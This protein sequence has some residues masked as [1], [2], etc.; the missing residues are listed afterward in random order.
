RSIAPMRRAAALLAL[1]AAPLAAPRRGGAQAAPAGA[2]R[3]GVQLDDGSAPIL[4][5]KNAG[6]FE[7]AG[8]A[9]DIQKF[10]SGT[11]AAAAVAGGSLEIARSNPVALVTAHAKDVPFQVIAP[12]DS[13][14]TDHPDLGMI[15]LTGSKL[16]AARDFEGKTIAVSAL[17]D[18]YTL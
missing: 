11:A 2:L 16:A 12:V 14:H 18:F 5:A 4:W 10:T 8:L 7:K 1:S 13:Y 3:I 9:V 15:V 6:L 17:G